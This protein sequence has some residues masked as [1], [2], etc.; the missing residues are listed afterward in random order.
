MRRPIGVAGVAA[1]AELARMPLAAGRGSRAVGNTHVSAR[2]ALNGKIEKHRSTVPRLATVGF[3]AKYG[4]LAGAPRLAR[5]F[6]CGVSVRA[7]WS[8]RRV[9]PAVRFVRIAVPGVVPVVAVLAGC[10]SGAQA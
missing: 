9:Q 10:S 7:K 6:A 3:C 2:S 5:V 1:R 4:A 8:L